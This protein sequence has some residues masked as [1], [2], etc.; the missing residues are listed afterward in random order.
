[1]DVYSPPWTFALKRLPGLDV[2]KSSAP[3]FYLFEDILQINFSLR[4]I[5]NLT[6]LHTLSIW[7]HHRALR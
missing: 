6:I 7:Y 3:G 1:M 4:V 5:H 2:S